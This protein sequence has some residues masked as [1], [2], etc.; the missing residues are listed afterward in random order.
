M[1]TAAQQRESN[2]DFNRKLRLEAEFRPTIERIHR[3]LTRFFVRSVEAG[4]GVPDVAAVERVALTPELLAH[5]EKVIDVFSDNMNRQLP[6][7]VKETEEERE[8]IAAL[9]L[10]F[11]RNRAPSQAAIIS[12]TSQQDAATALALA[13]S[14]RLEQV[15]EGET[16]TQRDVAATAGAIFSRQLRARTETIV[17][18]ETQSAAE[19]S[20]RTEVDVLLQNLPIPD[21]GGA[22]QTGKVWVSQGDNVVRPAHVQADS[23]VRLSSVPFDV[24]GEKLMEPGDTTL[25]ASIGN[26]AGCRCSAVYD[27]APIISARRVG[28]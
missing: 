22:P 17:A 5:Y 21:G 25:G 28:L 6:A 1:T 13:E 10:L 3:E 7:D 26:V 8:A 14:V 20:K 27:P 18:T 9:L 24:A 11:S 16:F 23:Q 2:L 4:P 19:V 12:S 15:D